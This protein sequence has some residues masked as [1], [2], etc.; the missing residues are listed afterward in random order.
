MILVDLILPPRCAFCGKI[1]DK[2]G[3]GVCPECRKELPYRKG[4]AG[5]T[6]A[7]GFP[8]AIAM[9]YD[10]AAAE[11]IRAMKFRRTA[12]RAEVFGRYIA[13]A[14]KVFEGR[15][16]SIAFAPVSWR[17]NYSRGFDQGALL[18][19]AVSKQTGVP[20]APVLRKVRHTRPQSSLDDPEARRRNAQGAYTVP[21][22]GRVA[23]GRFLLIDDV[24]TTGSTLAAC[25][26]ALVE[27]GAASV[28]CA[29]LAGGRQ[30]GA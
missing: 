10:G 27:A 30:P 22:A 20:V 4:A 13:Q 21:H 1:M 29:A 28:V 12:W 17:R 14:A 26:E 23:H 5:L 3:D 8:C 6:D 7:G 24:S 19:R 11:G 9:Y 25:G 18:A 2:P 15:Y 16:D